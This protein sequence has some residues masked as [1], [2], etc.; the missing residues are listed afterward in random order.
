MFIYHD[1][2]KHGGEILRY[3]ND[4][5]YYY[6]CLHLLQQV[7]TVIYKLLHCRFPFIFI[8]Q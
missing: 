1:T 7:L 5:Y 2:V 3:R 8:G 6:Y 4:R